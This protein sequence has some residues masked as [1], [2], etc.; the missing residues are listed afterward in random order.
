MSDLH[1]PQHP[2]RFVTA[3]SLFDGHDA[4]INIMRRILQSQGAEVI[5]LGHN[6]SVQEVVDACVEEDVQGV[7]VSSYQGG[8]VEYFEY[9]VDRLRD[10]GAGH[11]RVVG[12]GG[13]VIVHDEIERLRKSGVTIIVVPTLAL[14]YDFERRFQDH[15]A[16]LFPRAKAKDLHFAWTS[17]TSE[18]IREQ[19]RNGIVQGEQPILVTSPESLTRG[20]RLALMSAADIG[21]LVQQG[22]AFDPATAGV[23]FTIAASDYVEF[24]ILPRLVDFLE[25]NAP[26]ARLAVKP[27]DF[28][29]I[30]RQ[31]EA[32]DVDIGI[33]GAGFAPPNVRSRPLY[34]ER[35]M[36]VAR[37]DHPQVADRLTLDLFCELDHVLVSPSGG[38]FVSPVDNALAALGR[39]RRVRLSVPHFLLVTEI[40]VRSDMLAVL[41]ERLAGAYRD[42]LRVFEMP[43]DVPP[44]TIAKVWHERGHR[45]PALV[46]LR[47]ALTDLTRELSPSALA[48]PKSSRG[49]DE[50]ARAAA[51]GPPEIPTEAPA[52]RRIQRMPR[53]PQRT[54]LGKRAKPA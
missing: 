8:H 53:A 18:P 36:C 5:H 14:A 16:R 1:Q 32:G 42:R 13:G 29:A 40:I 41:P 52:P 25:A 30:G 35:F 12:G 4:S 22:G 47:Q 34:L 31:L 51:S 7:A 28:G 39:S 54:D 6:R 3:S 48:P 37:H 19:M 11:I 24:A 43:F 50:R 10:R 45:D 21:R 20:L 23:T 2:V 17:K 38:A 9:L 33:L 44:F 15:Y 27:M 26:L 49:V 46:W